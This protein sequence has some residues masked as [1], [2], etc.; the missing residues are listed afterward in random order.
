MGSASGSTSTK[1]QAGDVREG[2]PSEISLLRMGG[3]KKYEDA[4][5][6]CREKGQTLAKIE[7]GQEH[8][9]L[10]SCPPGEYFIGADDQEVE[11]E[12]KWISDG[13]PRS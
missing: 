1:G 10:N 6:A 4:A 5:S 2:W 9:L 7:P 8:V 11:G 13:T 12:W 3:C